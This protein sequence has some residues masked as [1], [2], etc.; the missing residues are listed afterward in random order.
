[1]VSLFQTHGSQWVQVVL[2]LLEVFEEDS[3][4]LFIEYLGI[5]NVVVSELVSVLLHWCVFG[6]RLEFD[7]NRSSDTQRP[8]SDQVNAV[9][10]E[11]LDLAEC[12]SVNHVMDKVCVLGDG[13]LSLNAGFG[14]TLPHIVHQVIVR[15]M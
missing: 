15:L 10:I 12:E 4:G 14:Q 8:L 3:S 5:L 2:R 9:V 1:M 6:V 7:I 13:V 11:R